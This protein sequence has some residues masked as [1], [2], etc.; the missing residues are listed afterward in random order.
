[1]NKDTDFAK[2][3][4]NIILNM[5]IPTYIIRT[6]INTN[7]TLKRVSTYNNKLKLKMHRTKNKKTSLEVKSRLP[8]A[9]LQETRVQLHWPCY[10]KIECK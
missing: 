3:N 1:M 6:Y 2:I 4:L 9:K 7:T 10:I 8:I 5:N